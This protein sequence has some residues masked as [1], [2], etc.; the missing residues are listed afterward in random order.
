LNA[1]LPPEPRHIDLLHRI[2]F[3]RL[4]PVEQDQFAS[5]AWA[6]SIVSPARDIEIPIVRGGY[7]ILPIDRPYA[8]RGAG[9]GYRD[10]HPSRR[11][12][13]R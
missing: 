10:A 12:H 2:L 5:P 9:P 13:P 1:L 4:N 6:I 11:C 3:T 7:F 8:R